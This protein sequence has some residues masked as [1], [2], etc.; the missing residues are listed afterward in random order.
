MPTREPKPGDTIGVDDVVLINSKIFKDKPARVIEIGAA[1]KTNPEEI[2]TSAIVVTFTENGGAKKVI[3]DK[4]LVT[5]KSKHIKTEDAKAA[6]DMSSIFDEDDDDF[7][8]DE[9]DIEENDEPQGA[10]DMSSL[11]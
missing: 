3:V 6:V 5:L 9:E 10:I 4:S 1:S 8:T 7:I 11:F 2:D